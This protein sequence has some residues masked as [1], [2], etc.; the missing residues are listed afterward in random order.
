MKVLSFLL[1]LLLS[2]AF[3]AHGQAKLPENEQKTTIKGEVIN[4]ESGERIPYVHVIDKTTNQG[5]STDQ[6]GRFEIRINKTDTLIFSAVGFDKDTL[7]LSE[8]EV[9]VDGISQILL[10]PSTLELA[11]I[12]VFAYKDEAAF[13]Q[14]ILD[15]KLPEENS[16]NI[17]IPGASTGPP[18]DL[19]GKF[20]LASPLTA[21]QNLFSKEAKELRKYQEVLKNYP[22]QKLIREKYNRQVV[23][24]ITGLKDDALND[25]MLFCNVSDDFII[26]ANEYEI[27]LAVNKC[28]KDFLKKEE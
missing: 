13:K 26:K 27:V 8:M 9:N 20:A 22:Q 1:F 14:A 15:L 19:T 25:F 10:S 12:E 16:H 17:I 21:V 6:L 3:M 4:K 18:K 11:P 5:T 28:Y 2:W 7:L 23:E 24:E